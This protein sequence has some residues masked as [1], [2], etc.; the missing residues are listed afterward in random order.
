MKRLTFAAAATAL[1]LAVAPQLHAQAAQ[2]GQST[3]P[4]TTAQAKRPTAKRSKSAATKSAAVKADST[5]DKSTAKTTPK[6]KSR[7]RKAKAD[8]AAKKGA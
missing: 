5:A 8:T 7:S 1:M 6:R 4:D 2:Q 3:K